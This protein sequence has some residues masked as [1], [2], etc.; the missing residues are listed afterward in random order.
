MGHASKQLAA[1][2]SP[3]PRQALWALPPVEFTLRLSETANTFLAG[4][5]SSSSRKA[6]NSTL[7]KFERMCSRLGLDP[8]PL[9]QHTLECFAA[10]HILEGNSS[11]SLPTVLSHL[12]Y[13]HRILRHPDL[14]E[15]TNALVS[16][17]VAGAQK[18]YPRP[19]KHKTPLTGA[20]IAGIISHVETDDYATELC[21]AM[22]LLGH[23]ALLRYK[24]LQQ[25]RYADFAFASDGSSLTLFIHQAKSNK[26]GAPETIT[27]VG[28]HILSA[29][30]YLGRFWAKHQLHTLSP[31][32]A[33]QSWLGDFPKSAFLSFLSTGTRAAGYP[34]SAC[35]GH[36][37]RAGGATD[38]WTAGVPEQV[39]MSLG[40]WKSDAFRAYITVNLTQLAHISYAAFQQALQARPLPSLIDPM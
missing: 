30:T 28:S 8:F 12:R 25:L 1:A 23:D 3:Q 17:A 18:L 35:S 39:I 10:L 9:T 37:M 24:E 36:S 14:S 22:M 21:V 6:Y 31:L 15:A 4:T 34:A 11:M 32:Q 7:R 38:L 13:F 33:Q 5:V 2:R 26:I 29:N 40:R 16:T 19:I 20:L 27:L